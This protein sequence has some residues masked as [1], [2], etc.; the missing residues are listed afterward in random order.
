MEERLR[1]PSSVEWFGI[2]LALAFGR[3]P[4]YLKHL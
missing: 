3:L 1:E 2:P 4:L